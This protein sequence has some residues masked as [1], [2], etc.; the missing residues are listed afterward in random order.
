MLFWQSPVQ[1]QGKFL[2]DQ[3][4]MNL[5]ASYRLTEVL[6]K[7]G[8]YQEGRYLTDCQLLG[9]WLSRS[10]YAMVPTPPGPCLLVWLRYFYDD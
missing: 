2:Q 1:L 10:A 6:L 4:L 7:V 8:Q 5:I 9:D 3:E